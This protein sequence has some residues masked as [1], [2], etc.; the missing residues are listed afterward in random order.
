MTTALPRR[1][2]FRWFLVP[3]VAVMAVLAVLPW[4]FSGGEAP[5]PQG[6]AVGPAV[7]TSKVPPLAD[8]AETVQRPLFDSLR[9]PAKPADTPAAGAGPTVIG[10][11]RLIG[12]ISAG[13][14][15]QAVLARLDTGRSALYSLDDA[16]DDW[17]VTEVLE[18]GLTVR[19]GGETETVRL[20]SGAALRR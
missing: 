13:N 5:A 2:P 9:Q 6:V 20:K 15:R 8:L 10:R 18:D 14:R 1:A 19:R 17:K 7:G 12:V 4:L 3:L 16:L 11:Y